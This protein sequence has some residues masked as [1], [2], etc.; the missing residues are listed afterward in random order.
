MND[1]DGLTQDSTSVEAVESSRYAEFA[2]RPAIP[3]RARGRPPPLPLTASKSD[4]DSK[5]TEEPAK[6]ALLQPTFQQSGQLDTTPETP[7]MAVAAAGH[8]EL[9]DAGRSPQTSRKSSSNSSRSISSAPQSLPLESRR[10][11]GSASILGTTGVAIGTPESASSTSVN[12]PQRLEDSKS[13]LGFGR[14]MSY[15]LQVEAPLSQDDA[16]VGNSPLASPLKTRDPD[17]H[18]RRSS[19]IEDLRVRR[20]SGSEWTP[21]GRI[22]RPMGSFSSASARSPSQYSPDLA[23]SSRMPSTG[24][25]TRRQQQ[26]QDLR[27]E[28]DEENRKRRERRTVIMKDGYKVVDGVR[29]KASSSGVY[30]PRT[31]GTTTSSG[32]SVY[33][34]P[35]LSP[36]STSGLS[37]PNGPG[38]P[39]GTHPM[40]EH[41]YTNHANASLPSPA[42]FSPVSYN[43]MPSPELL[44]SASAGSSKSR[45][46]LPSA[47]G[48]KKSSGLISPGDSA[49]H[50]LGSAVSGMRSLSV[51]IESWR[52]HALPSSPH[53]RRSVTSPYT[54]EYDDMLQR[55]NNTQR[56]SQFMGRMSNPQAQYET[57]ASVPTVDLPS[58]QSPRRQSEPN[59]HRESTTFTLDMSLMQLDPQQLDQQIAAQSSSMGEKNV[60]GLRLP[61]SDMHGHTTTL[62]VPAP[63]PTESRADLIPAPTPLASSPGDSPGTG[64][65]SPASITDNM[66]TSPLVLPSPSSGLAPPLSMGAATKGTRRKPVPSTFATTLRPTVANSSE[67]GVPGLPS[68]DEFGVIRKE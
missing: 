16:P 38:G 9:E 41:P 6:E 56:H 15:T 21:P 23:S 39:L 44:A 59:Q 45:H 60:K 20:E 32:S 26:T 66:K 47:L 19:S 5:S 36:T 8:S 40:S 54:T 57:H 63:V 34:P 64:L 58:S 53:N 14:N 33:S 7:S 30:T 11:S 61:L 55:Q 17:D 2:K 28:V 48:R 46:F 29:A 50:I 24:Y 51:G 42:M 52:K 22:S 49:H 67:N 18:T 43:S 65:L 35:N 3:P 27:S 4:S 10:T 13:H 31:F 25:M 12:Q 37:T 68:V 62:P 1:I